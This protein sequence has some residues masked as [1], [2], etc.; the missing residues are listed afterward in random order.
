MNVLILGATGLLGNAMFRVLSEKEGLRVF[1]TIRDQRMRQF[2]SQELSNQLLLVENLEE[3]AQLVKLFDTVKPNIVVNCTA[4]SK[5]NFQDLIKMVSIFS[6]LPKRLAYLCRLH[7]VRLV[8]ISTDCVFSG[9]HGGYKEDDFP[10]GEGFYSVAKLLGEV[11]EPGAITLRTSMIGHELASKNSLLEWFLSQD[12]ECRG[13]PKAIFSGFPAVVLAQI[14]R[15]E[16]L[17]RPDLQGIF[18]LATR[19]I[20]K[21]DLLQAISKKY[22][23][24]T[25]IIPDNSVVIDRSLSADK[26]KQATGYVPPEWPELIDTMYSYKFGLKENYVH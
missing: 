1:G 9:T 15:D 2:F 19:P 23:L 5:S 6:L 10:D 4:L 13:F 14:I 24:S 20:S 17:P 3:Q 8:H 26:F 12:E 25:R 21:F 22:S 18:H 11:D 16:I 7:G